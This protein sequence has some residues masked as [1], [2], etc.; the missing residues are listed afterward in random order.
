MSYQT[1]TVG[2]VQGTVQIEFRFILADASP[3]PATGYEIAQV[4]A[5]GDAG[6]L[7]IEYKL[8]MT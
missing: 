5:L 6:N 4:A 2:T 7:Y 1:K 3:T 8:T